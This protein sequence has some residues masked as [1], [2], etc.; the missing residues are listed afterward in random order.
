MA[1]LTQTHTVPGKET[2]LY[3]D[4][5]VWQTLKNEDVHKQNDI[6]LRALTC[7]ASSNKPVDFWQTFKSPPRK[8]NT[9][10]LHW[11]LSR[12]GDLIQDIAYQGKVKHSWIEYGGRKGP[13]SDG[14][15]VVKDT[16]P[17]I[18]MQGGQLRLHVVLDDSMKLSTEFGDVGIIESLRVRYTL[19]PAELRRQVAHSKPEQWQGL[20]LN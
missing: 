3:E 11:D 20:S 12:E 2:P 7:L 13:I 18:A 10:A 4:T 1:T 6:V 9:T 8:A 17:L 19:L 5:E 15:L 16:L 14:L